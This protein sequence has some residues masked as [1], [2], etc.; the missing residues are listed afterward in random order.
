MRRLVATLFLADALALIID[1][2][3]GSPHWFH[4][5]V[6]WPLTLAFAVTGIVHGASIVRRSRHA[7]AD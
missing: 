3:T 7:A 1:G 4:Y 2:W 5:D 6:A